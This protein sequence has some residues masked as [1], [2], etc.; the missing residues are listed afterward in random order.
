MSLEKSWRFKY[1]LILHLMHRNWHVCWIRPTTTMHAYFT[2]FNAR[3]SLVTG[4]K[5]HCKRTVTRDL[6]IL[7]F[8]ITKLLL[9]SIDMPGRISNL[10]DILTV[11][12]FLKWHFSDDYCG[13]S[14]KIALQEKFVATK[15]T[16]ES[17]L[18]SV[19]IILESFLDTR[20]SFYNFVRACRNLYR[21]SHSWSKCWDTLAI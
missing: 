16:R 3:R 6:F 1:L 8:N 5:E 12:R 7:F 15:Y 4:F 19:F 10:F 2:Y 11:I 20:L 9:V 17:R 14:T 18:P 13:E 21:D